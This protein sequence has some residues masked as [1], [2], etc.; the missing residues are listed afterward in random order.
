MKTFEL[1]LNPNEWLE[2][3]HGG[4]FLAFDLVA[5]ATVQALFT[6]GTGTP[7]ASI[8]GNDVASWG[9]DWDFSAT[10]MVLGGQCIWVK[11]AGIIRGIR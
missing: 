9:E 5:S 8:Q 4:H 2:I 3:L 10:N 7:L 1:D 6:E 11:G